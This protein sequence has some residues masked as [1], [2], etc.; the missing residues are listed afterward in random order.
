MPHQIGKYR[1]D[2]EI[3]RGAMGVVHRAWD[4]VLERPVALK[5]LAFSDGLP[6]A[7]QQEMA[8]RFLREARSAAR[9]THPN[10]VQVYDVLSVDGRH[11]IAME[12]LE[13]ASLSEYML[14]GPMQPSAALAVLTQT[15]DGLAAAHAA[16]VVHRDIKPD[17]VFVLEDGRVKVTDFGIAKMMDGSSSAAMTQFGTVIGTPGYMSPEQVTGIPVDARADVFAVGVLGYELLSGSNPFLASSS[18]ATLYRIVNEHPPSLAPHGVPAQ[19]DAVI[20]RAMSKDPAARFQSAGDMA[21]ALRGQ[22]P[23]AIA[24]PGAGGGAKAPTNTLVIVGVVALAVTALVAIFA[25][26]GTPVATGPISTTPATQQAPAA[27]PDPAPSAPVETPAPPAVVDAPQ[28]PFW[29]A[30]YSASKDE[31]ASQ[32]EGQRL[33]GLGMDAVVL[34]TPNYTTIGTREKPMWVV[35][36]GPFATKAEAAAACTQLRSLGIEGAYPKVVDQ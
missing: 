9:L 36:A 21:A 5:E 32:A 13:G 8:D 28:T 18:T 14:S 15:L 3:G 11:Y 25:S 17:N 20:L 2:Q 1:V 35:G 7:V 12:L 6:P 29:A 24:H 22:A 4:T 30:F 16:G 26:S 27:S 33:R 19:L 34:Y 10:V 23:A 31:A